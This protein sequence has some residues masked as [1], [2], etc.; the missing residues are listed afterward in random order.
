MRQTFKGDTVD[1]T[2]GFDQ[3]TGTAHMTMQAK[4]GAMSVYLDEFRLGMLITGLEQIGDRMTKAR[5]RQ[6]AIQRAP[7]RSGFPF[8][9][10]HTA[11]A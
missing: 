4:D 11:Q 6:A 9:K 8:A 3:D 2:L 5:E 10:Q 1:V 7:V